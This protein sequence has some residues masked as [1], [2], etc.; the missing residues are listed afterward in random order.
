MDE[1]D[2]SES[3]GGSASEGAATSVADRDSKRTVTGTPPRYLE[4]AEAGVAGSPGRLNLSVSLRGPIPERMPDESSALRIG[5]RL[6]T[7]SGRTF[8]FEANCVRAGWDTFATGGPEEFPAPELA[9][10]GETIELRVDPAYMGGIQPFE[11]IATATWSGADGD[12]AFDVTP[13]T[14]LANYP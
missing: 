2:G 5:F 10:N 9:L 13:R 3:N 7:K 14:G 8:T 6:R 4:I 12:Y 1:P 11:W